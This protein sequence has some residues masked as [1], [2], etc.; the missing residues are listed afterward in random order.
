MTVDTHIAYISSN[1]SICTRR[2]GWFITHYTEF[3]FSVRLFQYV[4]LLSPS[5]NIYGLCWH[6][7]PHNFLFTTSTTAC[8][9]PVSFVV[10]NCNRESSRWYPK[11]R[12]NES[13]SAFLHMLHV[14]DK[15]CFSICFRK[16][17][18]VTTSTS[19]CSVSLLRNVLRRGPV[20]DW[21]RTSY[22][23]MWPAFVFDG[24]QQASRTASNMEST[25]SYLDRL[26]IEQLFPPQIF[27]SLPGF[28]SYTFRKWQ[29]LGLFRP[30]HLWIPCPTFIANP[31]RWL[32][33]LF[34]N[35]L[36]GPLNIFY[37]FQGRCRGFRFFAVT[38]FSFSRE[39]LLA[40]PM[41]LSCW[42]LLF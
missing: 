14:H 41:L 26:D 23:K 39:I 13:C 5:Q 29:A 35:K 10:S 12:I 11:A 19:L 30:N 16:A 3:F 22:F 42:F 32:H 37:N 31:M 21:L 6:C 4:C 33:T 27:H 8:F 18:S 2:N 38:D 24:V 40:S 7:C 1:Y 34:C 15:C 17:D 20:P 9:A 36:F 25:A 28:S